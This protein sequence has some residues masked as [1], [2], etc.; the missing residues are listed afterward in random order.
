[1]FE[2]GVTEALKLVAAT[3]LLRGVWQAAITPR[4]PRRA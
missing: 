1:M 2:S 3:S 4:T